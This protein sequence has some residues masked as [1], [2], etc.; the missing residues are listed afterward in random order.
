MAY[1]GNSFDGAYEK[2]P[3]GPKHYSGETMNTTLAEIFRSAVAHATS[4]I[5]WYGRNA[6]TKA[7]AAKTLRFAS[8]ILFALGTIAPISVAFLLQLTDRF[9]TKAAARAEWNLFDPEQCGFSALLAKLD[10]MAD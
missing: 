9:G 7:R 5:E 8:L 4:R 3:D 10:Q 6:K 2:F 1:L